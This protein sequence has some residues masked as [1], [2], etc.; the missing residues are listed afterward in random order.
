MI[1]RVEVGDQA[2]IRPQDCR[3]S[4]GF[5]RS[6]ADVRMGWRREG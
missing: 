3:L 2:R 1:G 4:P 6:I 5:C